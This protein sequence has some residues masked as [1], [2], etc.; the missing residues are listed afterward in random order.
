MDGGWKGVK[1]CLMN[2]FSWNNLYN[3]STM[4]ITSCFNFK[5]V[6]TTGNK[7][8]ELLGRLVCKF[9]TTCG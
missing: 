9:V 3:K 2:D 6:P 7:K 8:C 1:F 4:L 5:L